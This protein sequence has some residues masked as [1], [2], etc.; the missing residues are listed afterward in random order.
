[1]AAYIYSD[2]PRNPIPTMAWTK[3]GTFEVAFHHS[4]T[5][6]VE[7]NNRRY[8][9]RKNDDATLTVWL[10]NLVAQQWCGRYPCAFTPARSTV[11]ELHKWIVDWACAH[12]HRLM[13]G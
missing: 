1:M 4:G 6:D 12:D 5:I 8:S 11:M 9:M 7:L 10:D 2:E 3:D 13:R